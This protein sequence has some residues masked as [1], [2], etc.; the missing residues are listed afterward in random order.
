MRT[1]VFGEKRKSCSWKGFGPLLTIVAY[2]DPQSESREQRINRLAAEKPKEN[3]L[4]VPSELAIHVSKGIDLG[5][6]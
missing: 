4:K 3:G 2:L 5:A 6:S 1:T